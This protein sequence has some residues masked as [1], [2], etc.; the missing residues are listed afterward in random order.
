[1]LENRNGGHSTILG[2][3]LYIVGDADPAI[4]AFRDTGAGLWAAFAEESLRSGSHYA[5]YLVSPGRNVR[6]AEFPVRGFGRI[7]SWLFVGTG[8]DR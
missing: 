3:L 2:G 1:M 8:A 4:P 5:T 6:A 7:V